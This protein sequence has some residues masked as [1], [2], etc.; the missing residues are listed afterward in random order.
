MQ[1]HS[2]YSKL[3]AALIRGTLGEKDSQ[4]T[5]FSKRLED[6]TI[7]EINALISLGVKNNLPIGLLTRDPENP[8]IV[9]IMGVLRGIQPDHLLDIG[10]SRSKFIW[11]VLD[12]FHFLTTTS[13][14]I[15]KTYTKEVS[16]IHEGGFTNLRSKDINGNELNAFVKNQ[17]DVVT[18]VDVLPFI[19]DYEAALKEICRIAVRFIIIAVPTKSTNK[20]KH[21]FTEEK[22]REIFE[23]QDVHQLKFEYVND[24]LILIA[25][26]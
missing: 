20:S 10:F 23:S 9:K 19:D 24:I 7:D 8:H 21:E 26:K 4:E 12:N 13:V 17:F 2:Y 18:A 6:L 15:D 22:L 5:H 25:R 16:K 3:V 1:H 14:D 11:Q